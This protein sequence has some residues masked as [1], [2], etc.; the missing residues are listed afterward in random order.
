V[1]R[2][3]GDHVADEVRPLAVRAHGLMARRPHHE[4]AHRVADE[5]Y[6][7]HRHRP[8]VDQDGDRVGQ[9][10]PAHRYRR[11]GVVGDLEGGPSHGLQALGVAGYRPA[12]VVGH[13]PTPCARRLSQAVDEHHH[14][15][16]HDVEPLGQLD[17]LAGQASDDRISQGHHT[18]V[19]RHRDPHPEIVG[20]S[21]EPLAQQAAQEGR[22]LGSE[23]VGR[24][25][26]PLTA[27]ARRGQRG[28]GGPPDRSRSAPHRG[29]DRPGDAVMG[30]AD[31]SGHWSKGPEDPI[32][33]GPVGVTHGNGQLVD[34]RA[35]Q[36]GSTGDLVD[37]GF[38]APCAS[39]TRHR[40][41]LPHPLSSKRCGTSSSG[42]GHASRL[43]RVRR[44]RRYPRPLPCTRCL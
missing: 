21:V 23:G 8:P 19:V 1:R 10:S 15:V 2:T 34:Q 37:H 25:R 17:L 36:P 38:D 35:D 3:Q 12:L 14:P 39:P 5:G 43:R 18:T 7:R 4:P 27:A 26:S 40:R 28:P 29:V 32:G 9:H 20:P 6:L 31:R 42:D 22:G 33:H 44:P 11:A 30:Q 16:A 13:P 41:R 24:H